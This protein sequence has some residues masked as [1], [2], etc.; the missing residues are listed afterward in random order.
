M[1]AATKAVSPIKQQGDGS[2]IQHIVTN[3]SDEKPLSAR[4]SPVVA[5]PSD[6]IISF[7]V[8]DEIETSAG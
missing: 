3:S 8:L 2:P 1:P 6:G 4:P 7:P 5:K